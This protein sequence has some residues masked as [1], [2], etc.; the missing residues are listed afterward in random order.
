MTTYLI[1]API[2]P[3]YGQYQFEPLAETEAKNLLSGGFVSAIGHEA[4]AKLLSHVLGQPI[5]ENRIQVFLEMGDK[6][7]IFRLQQRLPEGKVL[8]EGECK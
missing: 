2:L 1:N 8:N 4:T 5:L 3:N 6:A 7:I